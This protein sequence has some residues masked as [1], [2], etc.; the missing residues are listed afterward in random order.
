MFCDKDFG[1]MRVSQGLTCN[2]VDVMVIYDMI[3]VLRL[4]CLT[5]S[6]TTPKDHLIILRV[7]LMGNKAHTMS[8]SI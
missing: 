3:P 2:P 8:S 6:K 7:F 5:M 4:T 1:Y